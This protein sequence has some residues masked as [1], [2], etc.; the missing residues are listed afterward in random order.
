MAVLEYGT[1]NTPPL[2]TTTV[3]G[4]AA[5]SGDGGY[6]G[7]GVPLVPYHGTGALR[8]RRPRSARNRHEP[9]TR[10]S[11]AKARRGSG[12][13]VAVVPPR[14]SV[15]RRGAH[16]PTPSFAHMRALIEEGTA[17]SLVGRIEM[18]SRTRA[19]ATDGGSGKRKTA[20]G[21]GGK[22]GAAPRG[23][24]GAGGVGDSFKTRLQQLRTP[25]GAFV[26]TRG[27]ACTARGPT[28]L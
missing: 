21:S 28:A 3:N 2:S 1:E 11:H 7:A 25:N 15:L 10:R 8:P 26:I 14:T 5:G 27:A 20:P 22:S 4:A 17:N 6:G 12:G 9:R 24:M 23:R 13:R 16:Y 18:E 19:P